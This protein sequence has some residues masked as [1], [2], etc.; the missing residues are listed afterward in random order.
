[1]AYNQSRIKQWR[2][3]QKQYAFRYDYAPEG[4]ELVKRISSKPLTRGTWM[5]AL[6]A[7]HH[8]EWAGVPDS[9]AWAEV[10]ETL[11]EQFQDIFIE[12]RE[13]L[14]DLPE[15]TSRLW[16]AYLRFWGDTEDR[17][18]VAVLHDGDPAV[19]FVVEVPLEKW[20]I[21]E[22]F[23]GRIDVL[24]EDLEY[25]GL[26][27]WDAKWV[28][29]IPSDDERMLSP[30][31]LMYVWA[32]RKLGYDVRGFLYNYGRTKPPTIPRVLRSGTLSL[33]QKIDT[34]YD[35]YLQAVKDLHGRRWKS[36]AKHV[37]RDKLL[38]LRGRD[39]LWF[40][41]DRIPAEPH[42][43]KQAL[44]EYLATIKQIERRNK[45]NVAPRSYFYNCRF[46]CE[47][48]DLCVAEFNGLDIT[49]LIKKK[50]HYV[51]ERYEREEDLLSG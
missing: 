50:F 2:R 11:T 38:A 18:E 46:G 5:H 14:G 9:P 13:E 32:L 39:A 3:C 21:M 30:Q 27:V 36:Y 43:I 51:G 40:R 16:D 15:E 17:Y 41:R 12:E 26:W 10:Q 1:M 35:T 33:A 31:A 34:D 19:E 45:P 42:R 6:Q 48:H 4:Q 8:M 37:Y 20:G 25:G 47:Y 44:R 28:K 7:A 29:K 49:P 24:V 23:K 22:P